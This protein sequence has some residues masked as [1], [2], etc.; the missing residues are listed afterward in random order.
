MHEGAAHT[1][2]GML[3]LVAGLCLPGRSPCAEIGLTPCPI[4]ERRVAL[5]YSLWHRD[6]RWA[7]G[8][9]KPW[10]TPELGFYRSDDPKIL[11][12]HAE[13]LSGAG[14]DFV[15]IDWS[16]DLN[17]DVRRD[18]G[19]IMQ[20]FIEQATLDLFDTWSLRPDAPRVALMIGNPGEPDA[21]GNDKLTNKADEVHAL[22]VSNP[23]RARL[24]QIYLGKPL[25]LVY[26]NTPTPWTRSLP[27]WR[28]DRFTVRFMTGFITQQA[29]LLGPGG[30]SK[31]GYWS[32][33]DR[34][35][36]TYAICQGHPEC[37]TVVAAWR[38][39]GSPGRD[40]G[41]TF[42]DLWEFARKIGPRF[43]L[44]GTF[45]EWWVSE[46]LSSEQSKDLEPS[47]EHG[48]RY[49]DILKTEAA[50]LKQGE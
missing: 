4:G 29:P 36:P 37:V 26:V 41:R 16:N 11:S 42:T 28:D 18:A 34:G 8:P 2:R 50:L 40:G 3:S 46:Q 45:N 25:L 43:V 1:R 24:L 21:T 22:F 20:R 39:K 48:W 38:G 5:A 10:G 13:W 23:A 33:E 35:Q 49:M 27:P 7:D 32:W 15:V 47:K 17:M 30:V 31:Y 44:A 19:P 12:R 14:V 9:H 6:N